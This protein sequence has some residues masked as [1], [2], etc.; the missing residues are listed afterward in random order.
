MQEFIDFVIRHWELWLAFFVVLG[1]V[2]AFELHGR[3]TGLRQLSPQE[4]TLLIN[5][6]DA[7][8]LDIRDKNAFSQGHI[9]NS[10]NISLDQLG[11]KMKLLEDYKQRPIILVY[12]PG[13]TPAKATEL[14]TNHGFERV[15]IARGGLATWTNSGLP[16]VKS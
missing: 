13:Q 3:M 10:T 2:I 15:N 1:L 5:R 6:E 14:L 11:N 7:V 9:V 8:I 16:L 4:M 12:G